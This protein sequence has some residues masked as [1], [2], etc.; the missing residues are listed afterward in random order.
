MILLLQAYLVDTKEE[1]LLIPDWLK[2]LM[3]RSE[4]PRLIEEALTDLEPAQLLLFI[5]SFGIPVNSMRYDRVLTFIL[6]QIWQST[7]SAFFILAY[8]CKPWTSPS[9]RNGFPFRMSPSTRRT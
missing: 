6:V 8:C 3:I 1:A 2:L 5:Q 4:V 9:E 7:A